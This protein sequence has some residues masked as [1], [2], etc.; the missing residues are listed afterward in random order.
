MTR[1]SNSDPMKK[2]HWVL[3]LH[4]IMCMS[5]GK[6]SRGK[7]ESMAKSESVIRKYEKPNRI[8]A[9]DSRIWK[10]TRV[11]GE[12]PTLSMIA[13]DTPTECKLHIPETALCV[14]SRHNRDWHEP[15]T[16]MNPWWYETERTWSTWEGKAV[17][18]WNP[19]V[20]TCT[21][22][23]SAVG[24]C[25]SEERVSGIQRVVAWSHAT[26]REVESTRHTLIFTHCWSWTMT[27]KFTVAAEKRR[28]SLPLN[29]T[30]RFQLSGIPAATTFSKSTDAL[31]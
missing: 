22:A 17:K 21:G 31:M 18:A 19:M 20:P 1:T 10:D 26:I 6:W 3:I 23:N 5:V 11:D 24:P 30:D 29:R 25:G 27:P 7:M 15:A 2:Q 16:R 4:V 12:Y 13:V 8:I 28:S 9:Q 14:L